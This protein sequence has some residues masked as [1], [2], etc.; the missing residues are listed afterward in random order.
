MWGDV[1][2][3]NDV[4]Y[5][6]VAPHWYF[7][8]FMSFLIF[9][10]HHYIGVF[11]LIYLFIVIFFLPEVHNVNSRY[12]KMHFQTVM[13]NELFF[14]RNILWV[15]FVLSL[16]YVCSYLPYGRFFTSVGGNSAT[17]WSFIYIILYLGLPINQILFTLRYY[18]YSYKD[19]L[20]STN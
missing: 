2:C 9:C 7:R 13:D 12:S 17:T 4:R 11:G 20:I 5:L 1:G 8:P 19:S 10:P 6:S 14:I 3:M 18:F 16:F 15:V